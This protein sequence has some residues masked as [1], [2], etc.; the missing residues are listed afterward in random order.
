MN[1]QAEGEHTIFNQCSQKYKDHPSFKFI[2]SDHRH[3][4][5]TP[6]LRD[7]GSANLPGWKVRKQTRD[8]ATLMDV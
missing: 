1:N 7:P 2:V 6:T 5:A 8:I 3:K 4:D